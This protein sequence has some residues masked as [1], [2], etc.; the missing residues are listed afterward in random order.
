M[1]RALALATKERAGAQKEADAANQKRG[2]DDDQI[3]LRILVAG[4]A[5]AHHGQDRATR[6]DCAKDQKA[7]RQSDNGEAR[8]RWARLGCQSRAATRAKFG[9]FVQRGAAVGTGKRRRLR[10]GRKRH[11]Q[12]VAPL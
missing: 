8:K 6:T 10:Q 12:S 9:L 2:D 3:H 7:E 11:C 1:R 5:Q 4:R